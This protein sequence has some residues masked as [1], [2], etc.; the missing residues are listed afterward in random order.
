[1]EGVTHRGSVCGACGN[2]CK[3]GGG[4]YCAH[5]FTPFPIQPYTILATGENRG[6]VFAR[7]TGEGEVETPRTT[8]N[9]P[10]PRPQGQYASNCQGVIEQAQVTS[11]L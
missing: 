8:L 4:T 2:M 10:T 9:L 6:V 1:M 3:V 11:G 7:Q 5:S